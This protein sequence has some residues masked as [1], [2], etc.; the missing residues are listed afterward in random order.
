MSSPQS[1]LH[2]DLFRF[3]DIFPAHEKPPYSV[4]MNFLNTYYARTKQDL[5]RRRNKLDLELKCLP[6]VM[7]EAAAD[8]FIF[9]YVRD[10]SAPL[11]LQKWPGFATET[12]GA[13]S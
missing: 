10:K 7:T 4:V 6:N 2:N 12:P 13:A 9:G 1:R 5:E 3:I 8:L 11:D